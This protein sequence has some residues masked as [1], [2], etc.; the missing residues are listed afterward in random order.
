MKVLIPDSLRLSLPANS[1][2]IEYISYSV[3]STDFSA[4]PDAEV[5]V[6]WMNT[7]ENLS[8]AVKGL[9]QLKLVQSLAAGPDQILAA[10]FASQIA[11][12]SG[13]GLHDTTVAEHTLAL[14]LASVRNIDG[15]VK[16]QIAHEWDKKTIDEQAAPESSH[17]YTLRDASI[18]IIGFGSIAKTVAPMFAAL[19]AKVTGIAQSSGERDGYPVLSFGEMHNSLGAFDIVISLLPYTPDVDKVFNST[20]FNAMK[21]G[22]VFIN[23]GRGRTVDEQALVTALSSGHIRKAAI[24]VT[25]T[26]PLDK[27]SALWDL[28]NLIITPHISGGRPQGAERLIELNCQRIQSCEIVENFVAR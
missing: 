10:G 22:S 1:A 14:A 15:L 4:T 9:P 19:G 2:G 28:P 18:L 6:V 21:S 23:V 27:E 16:A 20:F 26:E 3:T 12:A 17:L 24:D 8:A 11:V 7:A 25:Y 5:L 13:R